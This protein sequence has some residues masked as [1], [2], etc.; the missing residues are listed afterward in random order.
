MS[1]YCPEAVFGLLHGAL[2]FKME[3]EQEKEKGGNMS[4]IWFSLDFGHRF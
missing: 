3:Q 1:L 2:S 4:N